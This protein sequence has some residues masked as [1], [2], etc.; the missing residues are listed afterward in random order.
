MTTNAG[1]VR[2]RSDIGRPG[3]FAIT[4]GEGECLVSLFALLVLT[5]PAPGSC[6]RP[7]LV[8]GCHA[9]IRYHER[10]GGDH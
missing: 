1:L 9:T 6:V 3:R 7:R 10:F 4:S 5:W 8:W 2:R